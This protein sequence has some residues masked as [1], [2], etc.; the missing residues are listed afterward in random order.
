MKS[1][2]SIA[3]LGVVATTL[4]F[5]CYFYVLKHLTATQVA[6][7]ALLTPM[8]ALGA[9][10]WFNDEPLTP[11]IAGGTALILAGMGLPEI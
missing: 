5:S 4:G 6:M 3:Y 2:L 11:R 8:L 10:F 7:I 1:I 9:G